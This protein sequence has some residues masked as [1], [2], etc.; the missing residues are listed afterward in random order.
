MSYPILN[1]HLLD[2]L[3]V[4]Q[5][6]TLT[7]G[8]TTSGTSIRT[9]DNY[10]PS[11]GYLITNK[12]NALTFIT[13]NSTSN[14]I[15]GIGT[16]TLNN[17]INTNTNIYNILWNSI[18]YFENIDTFMSVS[19][20]AYGQ[21]QSICGS[22]VY[23]TSDYG[24]TW[25]IYDPGNSID[26]YSSIAISATGQYQTTIVKYDNIYTSSNY[27]VTW[28]AYT[29]VPLNNYQFNIVAMSSSGQYQSVVCL[30]DGTMFNSLNY[31]VTWTINNSAPNNVNW[32]NIAISSNGQYQ[33][34]CVYN[35]SIYNSSN[36][37]VTWIANNSA[38]N[39]YS[40]EGLAMSYT[41]QYQT[42]VSDYNMYNS[43]NYGVT[44]T[45]NDSAPNAN[46]LG[47]AWYSVAISSSGQ[48][49][50][51]CIIWG[52]IYSSSDYGVTWFLNTN[53]TNKSWYCIAM[54]ADTKYQTAV[55]FSDP[56]Y[57]YVY[58][59]T[60][61]N[62]GSLQVQNT[63]L[64][65][66]IASYNSTINFNN[67]TFSNINTFN[68][69]G[70]I[71]FNPPAQ[72]KNDNTVA[73]TSWIN[74]VSTLSNLTSIGNSGITTTINTSNLLINSNLLYNQNN[75]F[76]NNYIGTNW[77]V[78]NNL[79]SIT[80]N[81]SCTAM[82]SSGQYQLAGGTNLF[83]RS[84]DYGITW[85]NL[86]S[87]NQ[88]PITFSSV[89]ISSTG[90]YQTVVTYSSAKIFTSSDYGLTWTLNTTAPAVNYFYIAMSSSG[91][92]QT[93]V[94]LGGNIYN[95]TNYGVTWTINN[96]S[97]QQSYFSIAISSSGQYQTTVTLEGY[98]YNSSDYGVTWIENTNIA[99]LVGNQ[100]ISISISSTGQY[101]SF[102]SSDQIYISSDYGNTWLNV[103]NPLFINGINWT[104]ITMSS[105]GQY[106]TALG[107]YDYIYNSSDYG[108]TWNIASAI[109]GR[110][111]SVAMSASGYY[112]TV[113]VYSGEPGYSMYN[114]IATGPV[115]N[116][117][118]YGTLNFGNTFQN[119]TYVYTTN[120]N[121]VIPATNSTQYVGFI[122]TLNGVSAF[123]TDSGITFNANTNILNINSGS[124]GI[125]STT[126]FVPVGALDVVGN[127]NS[128]ATISAGAFNGQINIIPN[129]SNA[130]IGTINP[131]STTNFIV[132]NA[133]TS[134]FQ[135]NV[136]SRNLY[137][138]NVSNSLIL[139]SSTNPQNTTSLSSN[140]LLSNGRLGLS[141]IG[142]ITYAG[143]SNFNDSL[144][145]LVP[146]SNIFR[147]PNSNILTITNTSIQSPLVRINFNSNVQFTGFGLNGA[148]ASTI[149]P[150]EIENTNSVLSIASGT[151]DVTTLGT[152][153]IN[154]NA[155]TSIK[156]YGS[157]FSTLNFT[158]S[159]YNSTT[160]NGSHVFTNNGN[161]LMRITSN[162]FVGIGVTNPTSALHVNGNVLITG[163]IGQTTQAFRYIYNQNTLL[164]Q[165]TTSNYLNFSRY[166]IADTTMPYSSFDA[167]GSYTT[168]NAGVYMFNA[169]INLDFINNGAVASYLRVGIGIT[170]T[171]V[172]S[173][174]YN[175]FNTNS[176]IKSFVESSNLSGL[177]NVNLSCTAYCPASS[178]VKLYIAASLNGVAD[179]P[180]S[181]GR[182][183]SW[184]YPSNATTLVF[185]G[186]LLE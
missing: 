150:L 33:T 101:Q 64:A 178:F 100:I 39:S 170:T 120:S 62:I 118:I 184:S 129:T 112:Q 45:I 60:P 54:S 182:S 185:S 181:L 116:T 135:S 50:V 104:S 183:Y 68:A 107:E 65:S 13:Q 162:S 105:S 119:N 165:S 113:V 10:A 98:V 117:N 90:Q 176:T 177:L 134:N 84:S 96:T 127:I 157:N 160:S 151:T 121:Q 21:Y 2:L 11:N 131:T 85:S 171:N 163:N 72:S 102:V 159:I 48:Y 25:N 81:W 52:Q 124:V 174:P 97:I 41:G 5:S 94:V 29:I 36:Y 8:N 130:F 73:T 146:Q 78:N 179:N 20:S 140:V 186:A 63:L 17:T 87:L 145:Y 173:I 55:S 89:A 16:K 169:S 59:L 12:N 138:N 37:G 7:I 18:P 47:G 115:I 86:N 91:Q 6:T 158:G 137:Y 180:G 67:A 66:N 76:N 168:L 148:T 24:V 125:G 166:G 114:S 154:G 88:P 141:N 51:A 79:S 61:N 142:N 136:I 109:T 44:W 155:N 34:A 53:S 156:A 75:G 28:N 58:L 35:G 3:S 42:A 70:S 149:K 38:P 30:G 4:G 144:T 110:F 19:I 57:G 14:T 95:S 106:Q 143:L 172:I 161:L 56:D 80:P 99:Y 108:L 93:A 122:D 46:S 77:T 27:G 133:N 71:S 74:N 26:G 23:V 32:A 22:Y 43:I 123:K 147:I 139:A 153:N 40:W 128:T 1:T 175:T 103:N 49:Q 15:I 152:F 9:Y 31:G 83:Y 126:P 92:Y 132:L 111:Y 167:A 69:T 164:T 82:S